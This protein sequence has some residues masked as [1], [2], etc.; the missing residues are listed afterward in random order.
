MLV[1]KQGNVCYYCEQPVPPAKYRVIVPEDLA[2]AVYQQAKGNLLRQTAADPCY[3]ECYG[4]VP[5]VVPTA[6]VTPMPPA[7]FGVTGQNP[8]TKFQLRISNTDDDPCYPAGPK[9]YNV[10]D[11][12]NLKRPPG[13]NCSKK[14]PTQPPQK[15]GQPPTKPGG[16]PTL[17]PGDFPPDPNNYHLG[18]MVGI[19]SCI[20]SFP[21][22][23]QGMGYFLVGQFDNAAK[24]WGIEPGQSMLLK[25]LTTPVTGGNMTPYQQGVLAG[26][27][28]CGLITTHFALKGT[29]YVLKN[30]SGG[31]VPQP[32][33]RTPGTGE[34]AGKS[35]EPAKPTAGE[36]TR[37]R[38]R[39]PLIKTITKPP[40]EEPNEPGK[41]SPVNRTVPT[42]PQ[43]AEPSAGAEP[44]KPEGGN[45]DQTPV[46]NPAANPPASPAGKPSV[47]GERAPITGGTSAQ[48]PIAGAALDADLTNEGPNNLSN[49]PALAGKFVTVADRPVKLGPFKGEGSFA[50]VY[51]EGTNLVRKLAKKLPDWPYFNEQ[52]EGQ[53]NGSKILK[54][55][56]I[57]HPE[58]TEVEG[59]GYSDEPA[60]L[61]QEDTASKY[62]NSKELTSRDFQNAGPEMQGEILSAIKSVLDQLASKGYIMGDINPGNFTVTVKGGKIAVVIHDPDMIMTLG[63]LNEKMGDGSSMVPRT[64]NDALGAS[65]AETYK[66][67]A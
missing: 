31:D 52:I 56:G 19:S 16:Q 48:D 30:L 39:R 46:S 61:V 40:P 4:N 33:K 2:T 7:E 28:I 1:K 55:L 36:P 20:Q 35:A 14:V 12:P 42:R 32:T 37:L 57:D 5:P 45:N 47:T 6:G 41:P 8:P 58:V 24:M 65:G 13:C 23:G 34:P 50:G 17:Q 43:P 21:M 64:L 60:S 18:M 27:R 63:E 22:L 10:C 38:E 62:P 67:G 59:G 44:A 11:Y 29:G 66:V 49:A 53:A 54:S 51:E 3:W 15:A 9:N 25:D 26:Q